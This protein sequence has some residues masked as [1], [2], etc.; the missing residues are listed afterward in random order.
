MALLEHK[1]IE[2]STKEE[3][4]KNLK[5]ATEKGFVLSSQFGV[6]MASVT[7]RDENGIHSEDKLVMCYHIMVSKIIKEKAKTAPKKGDAA[8]N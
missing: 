1:V 6:S 5:E 3:Y 8:L 2:G 4:E 7:I